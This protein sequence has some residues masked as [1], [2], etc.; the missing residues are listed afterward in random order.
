MN[1]NSARYYLFLPAAAAVY[2]AL[3]PKYRNLFLL[4]A[5]YYFYMC[6]RPEYAA[7]IFLSTLSTYV[8]GL[9]MDKGLLGRR[10]LWLA[11][12]LALNLSVLFFFKYFNFFSGLAAD[13]AGLLGFTQA[14]GVSLNVL[15]PVGISFFTFQAL[16]YTIDVYRKD[17]PAEKNFID[18][19][20]FV[21]FFPQLVAGPIERSTNL[22][23]Q[24]KRTHKFSLDNFHEGFILVLWGL[25]KKIVIADRLAV[26]VNFTYAAAPGEVTAAGYIIAAAAFSFQIYCDFSA[27]SDI[28]RGSARIL[29]FTLMKNFDAPYTAFSVRDF[30][31]KWHISLSTWFKDYLYI[32]LGGGRKGKLRRCFNVLLVFTDKNKN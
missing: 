13:A 29:G 18:Y 4:A 5:S 20:L 6:W 27:Y 12:N 11:V 25:F 7:L 19:A 9:F 30:W 28:A 8:C 22:L 31:R 2:F 26:L 3:R 24:F 21:S 17:I 32:P 14:R 10:K 16:G 1:F 15:L 23:P